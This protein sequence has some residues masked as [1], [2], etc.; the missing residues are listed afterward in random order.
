MGPS[1]LVQ[2]RC[3]DTGLRR[4]LTGEG[5]AHLIARFS[6]RLGGAQ[7][8]WKWAPGDIVTGIEPTRPIYA[9]A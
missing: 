6:R 7:A 2:L 8:R 5:L 1:L 9:G 4:R 3:P